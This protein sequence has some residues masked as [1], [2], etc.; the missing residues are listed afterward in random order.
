MRRD[1]YKRGSEAS[2]RL[3]QGQEY[4]LAG[5]VANSTGVVNLT[6]GGNAKDGAD[7]QTT[8]GLRPRSRHLARH[9]RLGGMYSHGHLK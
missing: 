7:D 6:D 9:Q 3:P 2:E 4:V 5:D 8:R 1:R